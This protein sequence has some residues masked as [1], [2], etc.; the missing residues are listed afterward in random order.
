MAGAG[1]ERLSLD[2][3]AEISDLGLM[4]DG[5]SFPRSAPDTRLRLP[6]QRPHVCLRY[7]FGF[8]FSFRNAVAR[9]V[10]LARCSAQGLPIAFEP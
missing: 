2:L 6:G 7:P 5:E 1:G 9:D 8:L 4:F 10:I 3:I